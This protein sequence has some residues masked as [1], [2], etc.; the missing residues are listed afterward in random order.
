MTT[1]F[2]TLAHPLFAPQAVQPELALTRA[3]D[4][5]HMPMELVRAKKSAGAAFTLACDASG[6]DDKEIYLSLDIDPGYFSGIKKGSKTLQADLVA[7]FCA[8]VGNTIYLDWLAY[9][10]GCQLVMIETAAE[11]RAK[12]AEDRAKAAEAESRLM[13]QLLAGR[14]PA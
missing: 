13:R 11:A 10:V 9:Q 6:L 4:Q 2:S 8:V 7:T 1:P 12:V 3:P 5:V 14:V